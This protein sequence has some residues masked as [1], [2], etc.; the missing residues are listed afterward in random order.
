MNSSPADRTDD[1]R[2]AKTRL[3]LR[4]AGWVLLVAG[5]LLGF[6]GPKL[7]RSNLPADI[8]SRM[9][10]ID[11]FSLAW[12]IGAMMVGALALMCFAAQWVLRSRAH[13]QKTQQSK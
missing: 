5:L 13:P 4:V 7:T 11:W 3:H 9:G 12:I 1:S 8:S 2:L 10:D 6:V